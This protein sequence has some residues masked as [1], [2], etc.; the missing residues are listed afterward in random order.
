LKTVILGYPSFNFFNFNY[1]LQ[2]FVKSCQNFQNT[3]A[4][5]FLKKIIKFFKDLGMDIYFKIIQKLLYE[6]GFTPYK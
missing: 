4:L 6:K 3:L 5:F 1:P 2:F